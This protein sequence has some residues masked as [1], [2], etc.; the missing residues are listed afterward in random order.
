MNINSMTKK[1]IMN[2]PKREWGSGDLLCSSLIIIPADVK[3]FD[4]LKYR[5][6]KWLS[7]K[8]NVIREPEIYEIEGLH[9]SGFRIMN[10]VAI[11]DNEPFCKF[12]GSS[13]VLCMNGIGGL[14][15]DWTKKPKAEYNKVDAAGWQ[16]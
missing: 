2:V 11:I 15:K 3:T 13:D 14:G 12:M 8:T 4:V 5:F 7:G 9:D 6:L 1:E 10:F 16:N